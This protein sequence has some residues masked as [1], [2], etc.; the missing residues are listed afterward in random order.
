M[1]FYRNRDDRHALKNPL[2]LG[3]YFVDTGS[4]RNLEYFLRMGFDVQAVDEDSTAI[5][6]TKK[7][8]ESLAPKLGPER[9]RREAIESMSLPDESVDLVISSAVLHF[10]RGDVHF[11]A[12]VEEMARVLKPGGIF[13]CRLASLIGLESLASR[14]RP[15]GEH[16]F[17]LP[18]G[19]ERYCVSEEQILDAIDAFP[20]ILLDPL[21]T[22]VVQGQRAMTTWVARKES[23]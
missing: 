12:M 22:T 4:G 17:V 1:R 13:F 19:S 23:A 14:T 21:K 8:F 20:S 18:D 11:K 6:A 10:A 16:R 7:L 15:L 3:Q 9:V 2:I 5:A